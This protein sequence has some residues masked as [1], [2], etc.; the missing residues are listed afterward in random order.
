MK[1]H[2]QILIVGGGNA[3]LSVAGQLLNRNPSLDIAILEP[4]DRHYYQPG[5]TLV[6]G[7]TFD[8][9]NT[10][11]AEADFIPDQAEWI[12][13]S[14]AGFKPDNNM[15]ITGSGKEILYDFMVVC[16]GIQL[17]WSLIKGLPE[18]LGRNGVCSNYSF[19]TAS[20]TYE[21]LRNFKGGKALFTQP[22]SLIKCGAAPQ[23]IMYLAADNLR[24]R[25]LLRDSEITFYT[26]KPGLLR[27]PEINRALLDI[28]GRY[29]IHLSFRS[30]LVEIRGESKEAV[31][32]IT[33]DEST[34]QKTVP[35]DMIHVAPPMSAPDFI[36][37]SP[38]ALKDDPQG[39]VDIDGE[40]LQHNQFSNIFSLGDV[41]STGDTKTG[42]AVHKQAPVLVSNLLAVL[43]NKTS[44]A[45]TKYDGYTA[46]PITTGY[47]S[48]LLAEF[49]H[50]NTLMPT[51]P[52]DPTKERYSMW[53]LIKY[54]M[55]WLYWNRILRGKS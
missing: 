50:N 23:K 35:Y 4:S 48:L 17:D 16:A 12:Q 33:K 6:G 25:G 49:D 55:P 8:I 21:C 7:G 36:K 53:L 29:G 43:K 9:N 22:S 20:Y 42:A 3:G 37:D 13:D 46:C 54:A 40:T 11:R 31:F 39:W 30:E 47:G 24:K 10:V 34:E 52:L 51:F 44:S 19:D 26:G 28:A 15:V 38:L 41:A 14:A 5:W 45:V 27:V 2:Y 32:A 1:S 18:T